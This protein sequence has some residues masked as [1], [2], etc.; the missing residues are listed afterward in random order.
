[1]GG[2]TPNQ[3]QLPFGSQALGGQ[4][5]GTQS[6]LP[7]P[8]GQGLESLAQQSFG[9]PVVNHKSYERFHAGCQRLIDEVRRKNKHNCIKAEIEKII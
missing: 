9:F 3:M 2:Y 6:I 8:F 4:R 5:L 7:S 1:M